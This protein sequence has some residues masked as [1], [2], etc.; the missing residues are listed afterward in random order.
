MYIHCMLVR[1]RQHQTHSASD[2]NILKDTVGWSIPIFNYQ[3]LI[4]VQDVTANSD[5]DQEIT[6]LSH[7]IVEVWL[8]EMIQV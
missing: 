1:S 8:V 6:S 7:R 3:F 4:Y 5:C 2:V